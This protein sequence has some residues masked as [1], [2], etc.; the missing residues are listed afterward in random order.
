MAHRATIKELKRIFVQKVLEEKEYLFGKFS[1]KL[2]AKMK[3]NKWEEI[4]LYG[5]EIGILSLTDKDSDYVRKSY[6]QNIRRTT[7]NKK[8]PKPTGDS[9]DPDNEWDEVVNLFSI[10]CIN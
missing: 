7:L 6:W 5:V 9:P 3:D 10:N 4:R 1:N 2:N 8:R